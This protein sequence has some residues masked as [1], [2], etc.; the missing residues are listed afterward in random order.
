[1]NHARE[2]W[3]YSAISQYLK[4]PLQYF[5]E[6]VLKVPRKSV[7]SSLVFGSVMHATLA[8]YHDSIVRNQVLS[9]DRLIESVRSGWA[10]RSSSEKIQFKPEE[11]QAELIDQSIAMLELYL[12]QPPPALII[13]IELPFWVP[14]E[15]SHGGILEKPLLAVMDLIFKQEDQITIREFKTSARSYSEAEVA[16]SLQATSY[17]YSFQTRHGILPDLQFT[18]FVKT[19][20]PKVQNISTFRTNNELYRFGDLVQE[21]EASINS[22]IFYPIESPLNCGGCSY[23]HECKAWRSPRTTHAEQQC[24]PDR[25]QERCKCS[26]N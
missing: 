17:V 20:T 25:E 4:C 8:E 5:F 10:F 1:M 19:K 2:H 21:V 14:I 18:V 11:L 24:M 9:R 3:S 15:T 16:L 23:F 22:K 26:S 12:L 13:A 6:R 7:S